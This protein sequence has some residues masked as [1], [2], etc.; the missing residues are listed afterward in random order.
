MCPL[1]VYM[2]FTT[3]Y[4][5]MRL[6]LSGVDTLT[7]CLELPRSVGNDRILGW[8]TTKTTISWGQKG[9]HTL[10]T[11]TYLF[12]V[13]KPHKNALSSWCNTPEERARIGANSENVYLLACRRNSSTTSLGTR[14]RDPTLTARSSLRRII[15]LIVIEE[16]QSILPTSASVQVVG[17]ASCVEDLWV[18]SCLVIRTPISVSIKTTT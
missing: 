15:L 13:E 6:F 5:R 11:V 14:N 1:A 18:C 7:G 9:K 12:F 17:I 16:Q 3:S 4:E 2:L 10:V 8:R